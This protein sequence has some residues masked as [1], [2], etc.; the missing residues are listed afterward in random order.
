VHIILDKTNLKLKEKWLISRPQKD[1]AKLVSSQ[2]IKKDASEELEGQHVKI[3][4]LQ[5]KRG[6]KYTNWFL[7]N[8][9]PPPI[10]VVVKIYGNNS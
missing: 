9:W 2:E 10:M 5:K 1:V 8:H 3:G 4:H 6:L 7:P